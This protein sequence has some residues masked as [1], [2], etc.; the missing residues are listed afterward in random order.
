MYIS[1]LLTG[2]LK[3]QGHMITTVRSPNSD[4]II[5]ISTLDYLVQPVNN[6][7]IND[8]IITQSKLT[9]SY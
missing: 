7:V 3:Q 5:I 8:V 6:Y 1:V 2:T 4:T 9:L